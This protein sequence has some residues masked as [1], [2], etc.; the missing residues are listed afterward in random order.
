ML[1]AF[2]E[3]SP[4]F[5][6]PLQLATALVGSLNNLFNPSPPIT[7]ISIF[8]DASLSYTTSAGSFPSSFSSTLTFG[9]NQAC[10]PGLLVPLQIAFEGLMG[11][12]ATSGGLNNY[13]TTVS[14]GT[15]R[16]RGLL[17][18]NTGVVV[19]TSAGTASGVQELATLLSNVFSSLSSASTMSSM[20]STVDY[21]NYLAGLAPST[22]AALVDALQG[23]GAT[24]LMS[25]SSAVNNPS[26]GNKSTVALAVGL[27]IGL[28]FGLGAI[29]GGLF[30]FFRN[31]RRRAA[32]AKAI[33]QQNMPAGK[34]LVITPGPQYNNQAMPY[35]PQAR[36]LCRDCSPID[37]SLAAARRQGSGTPRNILD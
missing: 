27:S 34:M 19:M 17:A 23:V 30:F 7:F 1:E 10:Q 8:V 24:Y 31:R 11:D 22:K 9:L 5:P 3:I 36:R 13:I 20:Y 33:S 29:V 32:A 4:Y 12:V 28:V 25:S 18:S 14:C 21:T 35:N 15:R 37:I 2:G 26:S 6:V 16:R